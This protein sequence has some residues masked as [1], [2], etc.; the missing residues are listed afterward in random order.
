MLIVGVSDKD[1]YNSKIAFW[2]DVY[3]FKMS[4]MKSSVTD[5][6]HVRLVKKETMV[7][8]PAVIKVNT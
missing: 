5:E 1:L 3:G 2:D 4:C 8:E 7:T 6:V